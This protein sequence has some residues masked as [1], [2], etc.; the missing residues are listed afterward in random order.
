MHS[1]PSLTHPPG[2]LPPTAASPLSPVDE[3]QLDTSRGQREFLSLKKAAGS[4]KGG[5]KDPQ[6]S[7]QGALCLL[8]WRHRRCSAQWRWKGLLQLEAERRKMA[9][10]YCL[11]QRRQVCWSWWSSRMCS[12]QWGQVKIYF[13]IVC[14]K[15]WRIILPCYPNLFSERGGKRS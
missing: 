2:I 14:C 11:H 1:S 7:A 6:P 13:N 3:A 15:M 9:F 4:T 10:V 8:R 5:D 12:S